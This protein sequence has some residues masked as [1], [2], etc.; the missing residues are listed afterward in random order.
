LFSQLINI[1][2][3]LLLPNSKLLTT[4]STP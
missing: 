1:Q 4:S 2:L 3:T